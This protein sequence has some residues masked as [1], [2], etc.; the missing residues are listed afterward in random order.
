MRIVIWNVNKGFE[1]KIEAL[2]SL[3]PDLAILPESKKSPS[4]PAD[5]DYKWRWLGE[6]LNSG[7][8]FA[9]GADQAVGEVQQIGADHRWVGAVRIGGVTVI[10]VWAYL[11]TVSTKG[12]GRARP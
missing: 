8:G 12:R 6:N 9:A 3:E 11:S 7:L 10:G 4:F 1:R 5:A 2:A